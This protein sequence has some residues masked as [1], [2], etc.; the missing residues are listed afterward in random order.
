KFSSIS[1]LAPGV[2]PSTILPVKTFLTSPLICNQLSTQVQVPAV[3]PQACFEKN[4]NRA[5]I[6]S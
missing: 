6:L 5:L 2:D 4:C 3:P 1:N